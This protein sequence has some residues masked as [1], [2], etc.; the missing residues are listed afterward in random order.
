MSWLVEEILRRLRANVCRLWPGHVPSRQTTGIKIQ[1]RRPELHPLG[2]LSLA[3]ECSRFMCN[4][5]RS[6]VPIL[7]PSIPY[8]RNG[9]PLSPNSFE[10][11]SCI[12]YILHDASTAIGKDSG[13]VQKGVVQLPLSTEFHYGDN[14]DVRTFCS[15]VCRILWESL[16]VRT[17][18][19]HQSDSLPR[20]S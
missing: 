14:H 9:F 7:A 15:S 13:M 11:G 20:S 3:L 6:C 10:T 12:P 8:N 4:H 16:A 5:V 17:R 19:T 1:L 2:K 18:L